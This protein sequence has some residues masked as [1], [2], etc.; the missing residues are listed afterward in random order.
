MSGVR[1][2]CGCVNAADLPVRDRRGSNDG[3]AVDS[4]PIVEAAF[5]LRGKASHVQRMWLR[6]VPLLLLAFAPG[7]PSLDR[8]ATDPRAIVREAERAVADRR[9]PALAARWSTALEHH[10]GAPAALFAQA[11]IARLTYRFPEAS[12]D[13][14]QLRALSESD[15][16]RF[17][18]F[19]ALGEAEMFFIAARE[20]D[21]S[22]ASSS[23]LG[24]ARASHDSS[25]QVLALVN[26]GLLR[27]R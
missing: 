12:R 6:S 16:G 14:D 8:G 10:P 4:H 26:L 25:A 1:P 24:I 21:A 17:R 9:I 11:T 23:A 15:G 2:E 18:A 13:Y 20:A 3:I 22:T 5:A 27:L 19:S 7:T